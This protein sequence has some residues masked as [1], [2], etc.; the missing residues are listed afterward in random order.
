MHFAFWKAKDSV[1][2]S[3]KGQYTGK[4]NRK[5]IRNT[6]RQ[7]YFIGEMDKYG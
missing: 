6:Y 7:A 2:K 3:F 1:L 4:G 5:Q